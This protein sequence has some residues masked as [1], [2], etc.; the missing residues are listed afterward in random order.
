[1]PRRLVHAIAV[2]L[3]V[4]VV[5]VKALLVPPTIF[6]ELP[7]SDEVYYVK[8][9]GYVLYRLG[10]LRDEPTM[11]C[12][13]VPAHI[14]F[15]GD[16][17]V[18][19]VSLPQNASTFQL[20]PVPAGLGLTPVVVRPALPSLIF[21]LKW[22]AGYAVARAVM[23]ALSCLALATFTYALI[24]RYG[25]LSSVAVA[26][27]YAVDGLAFR[28]SY[29][30]MLDS[31]MVS[32][33][34]LASSALMLGR[35]RLAILFLSLSAASKEVG[36]IPVAAFALYE[37][38]GRRS[39][40]GAVVVS[41]A[42]AASLVLS[43]LLNVIV[44]PV[45]TVVYSLLHPPITFDATCR[46]LCL[47]QL[48]SEWGVFSLFTPFVWV[49]VVASLLRGLREKRDDDPVNAVYATSLFVVLFVALVST[50][51]AVY[52]FYYAPCVALSPI[53]V[54]DVVGSLSPVSRPRFL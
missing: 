7:I 8:V 30:M 49:W 39:L 21:S 45:E 16:T 11:P 22:V 48:Y 19:D 46:D 47:L 23:L 6:T 13:I 9:G 43:Y 36:L 17:V 26:T 24:R 14:S 42:G 28:L 12:D 33:T 32:F 5:V 1:M 51:R 27:V 34:L 3:P 2:L 31:P 50:A 38:V 20:L 4:A 54:V 37:L 18:L 25:P 44:A 40:R 35:R 10:L 29:V 53:A 52:N 15:E 41:A